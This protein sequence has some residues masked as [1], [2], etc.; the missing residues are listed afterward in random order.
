MITASQIVQNIDEGFLIVHHF[1]VTCT[2]ALVKLNE[3]PVEVILFA[4]WSYSVICQNN[5]TDGHIIK[6]VFSNELS[7]GQVR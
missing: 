5:R 4:A 2:N 6:V 7:E 1:N 3:S